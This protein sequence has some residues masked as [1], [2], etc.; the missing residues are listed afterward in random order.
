MALAERRAADLGLRAR[1][2]V[3]L[4][5]ALRGEL[6]WFVVAAAIL[7]L[8]GVVLN[9]ISGEVSLGDIRA[10]AGQMAPHRL[11]AALAL[12]ALS[13]V[14]MGFYDIIASR[15]V[16]RDRVPAR[17]AAFAGMT[18]YALSNALG[19]HMFVGGPVRYRIYASQGLDA[20]DVGRIVGIAFGALWLGFAALFGLIL[21]LD[22]GGF[23]LLQGLAP[24]ADRLAGIALVAGIL[25]LIAWVW[26]A[27]RSISLLR[28][29]MPLPGGPSTILLLLVGALDVAAAAG[30]L[31]ILLPADLLPGFAAFIALFTLALLAG[32]ASHVPGGLGVLEATLL[33]GLGAG[34]RPDAYAALLLFR[35]IY[36]VLPLGIA[37][38]ALAA[39]EG[40]RFQ[41]P[42]VR[43][44]RSAARTARPFVARALAGLVFVGG[45]ILLLSGNVPRETWRI[46]MLRDLV[47]LPFAETSHLMA[48]LMG[49]LLLILSHGLMNRMA[50]ARIAAIV[51]LLG[52]ATSSLV[53]GLDWEEAALL[54]VIAALL[55]ISKGAFYRRGDWASFRPGPGWLTLVALTVISLTAIGFFAFRSVEYQ[56][57]L[58]WDFTWN[59]DAPRFLRATLALAVVFVALGVDALVNRPVQA[60]IG[61]VEIPD[62]VR[63]LLAQCPATQPNIALLADKRFMIS[64]DE[65]AFLMY[66]ISGRSWIAMGDPVGDA[67]AGSDLVWRFAEMADRA[68]ARAVFYAVSP[69]NLPLYLDMGLA[70]LKTGEVARVDLPGFSLAG[71][72]RQDLRTALNRAERE[73]L[74][75]EVIPARDIPPLLPELRRVSDAWMTMK[76]GQEKGFSLG[77]FDDAY[78]ASFDV[79]VMRREG[80]IVAFANLW[81]GA[82]KT[83]IAID[84]MR[85]RSDASK[86]LMDALFAQLML[87]GQAQG[88]KWFSLGAAPLAGLADHPLAS[89]WNRV[90]TFIY[91]RGDE[92]F[93]FE[94]LR[95]YKQK[96]APVWTPVYLAAPGGLELPR[97]LM[98]VAGLISGG[99]MGLIRRKGAAARPKPARGA[100]IPKVL[101]AAAGLT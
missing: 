62:A 94:G 29:K 60:R 80:E 52:A 99:R 83:E 84:L 79:A 87:Y 56:T 3:P 86:V 67:A 6:L 54:Y 72:A 8:A 22:P 45:V 55:Y 36:Y 90:G 91:R 48:S 64:D 11:G 27:D 23:P 89:T 100:P 25:A 37:G 26:R 57:T 77:R 82:E 78:L 42:I 19:F 39:F 7:S 30:A 24:G 38:V 92:F 15:C 10:A 88:Y 53:K 43:V 4:P 32:T 1:R 63:R 95:A 69:E 31:Y 41:Q 71:K 70:L 59:G 66:G 73:G 47:P 76:K 33:V 74:R 40:R 97:A 20:A 58:W 28:W 16:A 93:N 12:T 81:R 75:F 35:L 44:S 101:S 98:D 34:D 65:S 21:V 14:G 85:Y 46:E 13:F 18:G 61:R 50:L 68:G 5:R 9:R 96:F 17:I 49:L 51:L 2:M